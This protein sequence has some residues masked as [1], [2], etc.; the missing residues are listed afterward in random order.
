MIFNELE[1]TK[2]D[3]KLPISESLYVQLLEDILTGKI[4]SGAKLT[5]QELCNLYGVSRTPVRE[6]LHQLE[7]EGLI[8]IIP[9]RGAFAVGFS[10]RD[11]SDIYMLRREYEVLAAG[12]AIERISDEQYE[13]LEEIFEFMEFYTAK[14]DFEKNAQYQ[15]AVSSH[16]LWRYRQ[17]VADKYSY[18]VSD[19]HRILFARY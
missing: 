11:I 2:T 14:G 3:L 13:K 6:A 18:I 1:M 17:Q 16:D 7:I 10:E 15:C 9:N 12:W 4:S 5:E 8:E 19:I